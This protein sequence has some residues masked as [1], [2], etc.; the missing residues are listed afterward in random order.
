[1]RE[2]RIEKSDRLGV[3]DRTQNFIPGQRTSI[4]QGTMIQGA[5]GPIFVSF[6]LH[7]ALKKTRKQIGGRWGGVWLG[8]EPKKRKIDRKK[9]MPSNRRGFCFDI[10][11]FSRGGRIGD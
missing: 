4:K 5:D 6:S 7:E 9:R 2:L 10:I 11:P 1:M 3:P 8:R